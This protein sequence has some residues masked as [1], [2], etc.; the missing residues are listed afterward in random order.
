[1]VPPPVKLDLPGR[2]ETLTEEQQDI[3]EEFK[4]ELKAD[5]LF[6]PSR[7]D[8]HL[9]LRFL[10]ARKF[11]VLNA[12]LMFSDYIKWRKEFGGIGVDR[13]VKEWKFPEMPVVAAFYPRTYHK[14]DKHGR[15]IYIEQIGVINL[16][17]VFAVTNLER[18]LIQH[19]VEYEKLVNYRLP[20]C[21]IAAGF[22]IEQSC[23]I[24]DLKGVSVSNFS[25]VFTF[26]KNVSAIAQNY[27]PEMLGK[28]Y[29]INTPVLFTAVWQLVKPMLDEVTVN[30]IEFLSTG[31]T[32]FIFETIDR[33]N[34]PELLGGNSKSKGDVGPWNDGTIP[35]YPKMEYEQLLD[36]YGTEVGPH[37]VKSSNGSAGM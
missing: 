30:K 17:Q 3:L 24:L 36:G 15:P 14:T 9:L 34:A 31:Y 4:E 25:R 37:G 12:K 32:H 1:M 7:H 16:D 19:V 5:D 8:N 28:M 27:Y 11:N 6:D 13:L 21:S 18:M 26:V 29:V 10:R 23:T 33:D 22:H 20:A 2:L 35:G